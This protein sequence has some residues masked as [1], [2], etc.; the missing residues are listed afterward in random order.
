MGINNFKHCPLLKTMIIK[1]TVPPEFPA[2]WGYLTNPI[3][4]VPDESLINY[5][6]ANGWSNYA[7]N[8]KSI[9]TYEQIIPELL[10]ITPN[11]YSNVSKNQ[12]IKTYYNGEEIIPIY[13]VESDV[14]TIDDNGL[15][16]FSDYGEATVTIIYKDKSVTR[17]YKYLEVTEV[18]IENGVVL[19]NNGQ[20]TINT[21]M[22]TVGFVSCKPSTQIKW[23]VTGGTLGILCEY[24][25]DGTCVDYWGSYQNPRTINVSANSTKVKAS[26]STAHLANAYIYDVT[27]SA[28]LWKGDNV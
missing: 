3:I 14:A 17:I 21:I 20:T 26:F 16:T 28:Y 7:H 2:V 23:G 12:Q 8:I 11:N 4:Y 22:S 10:S 6:E 27:N 25:E 13:K 24:K 15:L 5:Q 19:Q 9:S 1:A 18:S